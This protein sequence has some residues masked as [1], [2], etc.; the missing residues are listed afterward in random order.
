L[1]RNHW[2]CHDGSATFAVDWLARA[3]DTTP[4]A[5]VPLTRSVR[6][7]TTFAAKPK[8]AVRRGRVLTFRGTLRGK[9]GTPKDTADALQANAGTTWRAVK[10]IRAGATGRWSARYRVPTQ[11]LGRYRFRAVVNP[12]AAYPYGIGVSSTR[13]IRVR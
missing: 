13:R 12:S 3:R 1:L 9:A 8:R 7:A 11:L 2:A 10:T 5:T 6:A 4:A